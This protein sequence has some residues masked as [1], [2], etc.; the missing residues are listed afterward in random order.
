MPRGSKRD[1]PDHESLLRE[2]LVDAYGDDEQLWALREAAEELVPLPADAHVI[3]E[4]VT[5]TTIDYEGNTLR[6]LVA[7]VRRPG[8]PQRSYTV[9]LADVAFPEGSP[10]ALV[11][12]AYRSWL[13]LTG[14][15]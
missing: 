9:A 4:P 5:V 7:S 14:L 15:P 2:W 3:G 13:G 8:D 6:G 12:G 10:G 1:V 11:V